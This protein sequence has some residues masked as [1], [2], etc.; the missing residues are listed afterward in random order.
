[1]KV[2]LSSYIGKKPLLINA[3]ASW[4]PPCQE[5]TQDLVKMY[6]KYGSRVQFLGVNLTSLDSVRNAQSFVKKYAIPYPILLDTRGFFYRNYTVIGE[7]MTYVISPA[8]KVLSH[9]GALSSSQLEQ[10]IQGALGS[11]QV[12]S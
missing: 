10:L 5:E 11:K 9:I 1:M 12:A 6:T 8:G 7:P 4:C 2:K 3:W